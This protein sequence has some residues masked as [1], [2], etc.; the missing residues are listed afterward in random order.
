MSTPPTHSY[1]SYASNSSA[2]QLPVMLGRKPQDVKLEPKGGEEKRGRDD[3]RR[4]STK[5]RGLDSKPTLNFKLAEEEL[6]FGQVYI[7]LHLTRG[8]D[9]ADV[10]TKDSFY[11]VGNRNQ[12]LSLNAVWLDKEQLTTLCKDVKRLGAKL[13]LFEAEPYALCKKEKYIPLCMFVITCLLTIGATASS[14]LN[15]EDGKYEKLQKTVKSPRVFLMAFRAAD[16][17]LRANAAALSVSMPVVGVMGCYAWNATE[18]KRMARQIR[19]RHFQPEAFAEYDQRFCLFDRNRMQNAPMVALVGLTSTGKSS[20]LSQYL[21]ERPNPFYLS[22]TDGNLYDAVYEELKKAVLCLPF[23][24]H[25][26]RWDASKTRK[27][28]VIEVFKLVQ[29][30]TGSPVQ[31]GVDVVLNSTTL[32]VEGADRAVKTVQNLYLP[33]PSS[34]P[35]FS[36]INIIKLVTDVKWLC[37]DARVASA[38]IASS[39]GLELLSVNEPRLRTLI[40]EEMPLEKAK[41]YLQ[42]IHAKDYTDEMLKKI[43][44]TFTLLQYFKTAP[45]KEDFAHKEMEVW[46]ERVKESIQHCS[47]GRRAAKALF[48]KALDTV[49]YDDICKHCKDKPNFTAN[50]VRPSL[51]TPTEGAK[52]KLHSLKLRFE[53]NRVGPSYFVLKPPLRLEEYENR[54]V[55]ESSEEEFGE[56]PLSPTAPQQPPKAGFRGF[57]GS[58]TLTRSEFTHWR[59]VLWGLRALGL[60]VLRCWVLLCLRGFSY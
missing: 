40:A 43:P 21:K 23:L 52:Y 1:G 41:E 11:I 13:H 38:V 15:W 10:R 29:E 36:P 19:N 60:R 37:A 17:W 16:A 24:A 45:D 44:R 46:M 39:E 55:E 20:T 18:S 30:Q 50:F 57:G 32:P 48:R 2:G 53:F 8:I 34:V 54:P 28:I 58:G 35:S 59:C 31:L 14:I 7:A 22:L 26:V 49:D 47:R 42:H 3:V 56:D 6:V 12:I 4:M 25:H 51:F 5:K 9:H 27:D 33:A